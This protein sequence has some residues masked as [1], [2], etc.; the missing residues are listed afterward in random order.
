MADPKIETIGRYKVLGVLGKGAMGVVYKA[1]DPMIDREVAIKTIKLSLSEEEL[2][3]YEARFTQEIKTVGKLNHPHIVPIYDVGRTDTFAYM[4]MEFIDGRE[5]KAYM[6]AGTPLDVAATVAIIAQVADGLAFAHARDIVHRDVKPSN[7]MVSVSEDG[8]TAKVMDFGIARAPSSAV[9]TMTGMILGSPRYMSPEQVIGKN[10]GPH[11]DVFSLGVVL[12]E[13]LT[14]VAPFD[15]DS[16]SSIMYQTVHQ[17]EEP[18]SVRNR[19]VPPPLDAIVAKS[20][21]KKVDERYASM[22]EF[23]RALRE[24]LKTLPEPRPLVLPAVQ[25]AQTSPGFPA[26]KLS[27]LKPPLDEEAAV[28]SGAFDSTSATMRLAALTEQTNDITMFVKRPPGEATAPPAATRPVR[29]AN[30]PAAPLAALA[31]APVPRPFPVLPAALLGSLT[32]V[33]VALGILLLVR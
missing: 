21:A 14:G 10:V 6:A 31:D 19:E 9:K 13:M 23:Y 11:S 20:L 15:A 16:V 4:A 1:I 24:A 30:E 7:I 22:K 5:L 28:I 32:T 8:L 29:A 25:A 17:Q 33:A 18:C 27:D 3:L 12:Y 26:V 2:A